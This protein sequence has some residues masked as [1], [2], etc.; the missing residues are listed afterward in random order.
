MSPVLNVACPQ[1]RLSST[2]CPQ[3][4]CPQC[5]LSSMSHRAIHPLMQAIWGDILKHTVEKNQSNA[6]NVTLHPPMKGLWRYI[7]SSTVKKS[8]TNAINVTLHP[9]MQVVLSYIW[10]HTKPLRQA[11]WWI[12]WRR[13]L[14]KS[15]TNATN[16]NMTICTVMYGSM[17]ISFPERWKFKVLKLVTG[18]VLSDIWGVSL[19]KIGRLVG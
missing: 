1:R 17:M 10:K 2:S 4:R 6:T 8:Q 19:Q 15:H 7:W 16:V 14:E 13:A 5:R 12:T 11:I 9:L 18:V 3:R